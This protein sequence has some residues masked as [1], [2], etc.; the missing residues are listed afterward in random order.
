MP[1]DGVIVG[2]IEAAVINRETHLVMGI[3]DQA[4]VPG[5]PGEDREIAL[6]DT[7]SHVD[8]RRLAPFGNNLTA[9]QDEPSRSAARAH[10]PQ[11]LVPRR[12]LGE[13]A[14]NHLG[15]VAAPW[16]LMLNRIACSYG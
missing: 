5:E 14:C 3:A 13:I 16:R 4:A 12:A 1:G 2:R 7:E 11:R 8:P 9:P 10:R 6:G 15:Q